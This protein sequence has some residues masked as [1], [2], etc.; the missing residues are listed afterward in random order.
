MHAHY[1][2]LAKDKVPMTTTTQVKDTTG[3]KMKEVDTRFGHVSINLANAIQ[4]PKGLVGMPDKTEFCLTDF[5]NEKLARFKLMQS[6]TDDDLAF[7]T[8]PLDVDNDFIDME[9]IDM[10]CQMLSIPRQDLAMLLIVSVHRGVGG[11]KLSVNCV[12]PVF[13]DSVKKTATQ[14]VFAHTKY[15]V[16]HML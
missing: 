6:T 1:S 4:F 2:S 10:A 15:K 7:I 14:F 13:I 8:L 12:A 16:R 11:V 9:D 3:S 5:P